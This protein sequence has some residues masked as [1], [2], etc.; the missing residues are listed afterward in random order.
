MSLISKFPGEFQPRPAQI[1]L[2]NDIEEAF[3]EYDFVICSAPTG[4]G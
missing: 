3:K 1:K 2:I 4:T